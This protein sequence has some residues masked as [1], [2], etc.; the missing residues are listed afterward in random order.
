VDQ[1]RKAIINTVQ[2]LNPTEGKGN[3]LYL[4]I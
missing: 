1:L 2:N 3:N 4:I